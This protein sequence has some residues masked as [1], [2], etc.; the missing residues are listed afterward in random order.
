MEEQEMVE[1][2][3]AG[4]Q[5]QSTSVGVWGAG[6][7]GSSAAY[8]FARVGLRC[9]AYDVSEERVREIRAGQF[10]ST[11]THADSI[12]DPGEDLAVTAT[13]RWRDLEKESVAIHLVSVPTERA[14]EPSAAALED[15]MP[16]IAKVVKRSK[17]AATPPVVSI[18][19]TILPHWIDTVVI[20]ALRAEGLNPGQDVL[21]GAA[22]RRDWFNG[23]DYTIETLPRIVGGC[24]EQTTAVLCCVLLPGV[25]NSATRDGRAACCVH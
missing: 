4:L 16:Q 12:A 6:A 14:A 2:F 20:P 22:P 15:V 10:Q 13:I 11:S 23:A 3:L 8:Y 1:Q 24:D 21:I 7:I 19:S 17:P 18:E 25:S 9:V 5:S